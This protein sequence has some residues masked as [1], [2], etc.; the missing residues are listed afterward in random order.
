M[1]N[2]YIVCGVESP[3]RTTIDNTLKFNGRDVGVYKCSKDCDYIFT[4]LGCGYTAQKFNCIVCKQ[5]SG[6]SHSLLGL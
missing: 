3:Y 2:R 1:N 6:G 4:H 5:P